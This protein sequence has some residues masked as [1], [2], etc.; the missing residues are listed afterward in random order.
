[1]A[2]RPAKPRPARVQ[3]AQTAKSVQAAKSAQVQAQKVKARQAKAQP[4]QPATPTAPPRELRVAAAVQTVEA[5]GL[6][7]AA[8]LAAVATADGK[9]Y[10]RSSGIALTLITV[11]TAALFAAFAAGLAKARP[12]TRT[13]VVMFQLAI[14]AWGVFLLTGRHYEWGVPM[15]LLAA[16]T[17]VCVFTPASLRA[18]NRPPRQP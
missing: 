18:L 5:V 4:S 2:T 17:L 16:V 15:L 13:P 7:V 11:G 1:M 10:E 14:G 12:W 3:R 9:S 6:L 8:G